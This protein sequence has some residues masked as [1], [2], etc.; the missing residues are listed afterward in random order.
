MTNKIFVSIPTMNDK[1]YLNTIEKIFDQAKHPD[2][3]HVGTSI[4]WKKQDVENNKKPFFKTFND[5]LLNKYKNVKFDILYWDNYPGVGNGRIQPLKH[6]NGEK[7]YL[8]L[9]SHTHFV[10]EWDDKVIDLYE[11]SKET[12]GSKRMLTTYLPA[13]FPNG[14]ELIKN[15]PDLYTNNYGEA[16]LDQSY[17]VAFLSNRQYSKWQFFDYYSEISMQ[18]ELL[19]NKNIFPYP[20]DKDPDKDNLILKKLIEDR[21]LPAKKI[22]AHFTFTESDPWITRYNICLDPRIVFWAEEFY[23]SCL[24]YSR[25]YNF[26]WI[27]TPLFFHQYSDGIN[28][29]FSRKINTDSLEDYCSNEEKIQVYKDYILNSETIIDNN[30]GLEKLSENDIVKIL[31]NKKAFFGYTPRSVQSYLQY[32]GIDL[33]NQKCSP[34]WEVPKINV[35]YK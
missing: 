30:N 1:E 27:K 33:Y 28:E 10:K 25:G 20:N 14:S 6:F 35:V 22:S 26:V 12:F 31:L 23:Q 8:S 19:K 17:D 4:F 24:S 16:E 34:C 9:D 32:S 13:Y 5:T 7:Y 11:G 2:R 21:Y 29:N 3:I 15:F 18:I